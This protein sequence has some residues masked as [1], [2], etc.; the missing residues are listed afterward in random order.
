MKNHE[1]VNLEVVK[2]SIGELP[3][4][5]NIFCRHYFLHIREKIIPIS[6]Y[7]LD[8]LFK[9]IQPYYKKNEEIVED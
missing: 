3:N 2:E 1:L 4:H 5:Q 9:A 7:E 6:Q 8:L